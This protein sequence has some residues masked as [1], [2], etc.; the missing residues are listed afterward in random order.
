MLKLR[1]KQFQITEV[2][3]RLPKPNNATT[4][5]SNEKANAVFA[6]ACT[7]KRVLNF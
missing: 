6:N 2:D 7:L 1:L 3:S 5:F 4:L